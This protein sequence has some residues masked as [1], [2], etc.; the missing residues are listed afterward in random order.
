MPKPLWNGFTYF[1][2]QLSGIDWMLEKE[3]VGTEVSLRNKE[4]T[5][6]VK[7]GFQCDDMGLGKTIQMTAVMV[8][9]VVKKTL[10]IAPL[11]MID[12]WS[13]ICKRA[14]MAVFEVDKKQ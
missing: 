3:L 9:H 14:G 10:L 12:T 1:P 7:G 4:G 6:L 11:S 5:T 13:T 2:H 8:N